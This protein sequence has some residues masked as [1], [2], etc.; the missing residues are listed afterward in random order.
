MAY[1]VTINGVDR[2]TD[3][4]SQSIVIEDVIND[5]TNTCSF[6]LVNNSGNGIPSN[7]TEIVITDD[8]GTKLF[9]GYV[10]KTNTINAGKVGGTMAGVSCVDYV[11]LLDRNLVHKSYENQTDAQIIADIVSTYCPGF[12]ITTTNVLTGVTIEQISFNY[13]QVSQAMRKICE[14]TG[15]NWYID[16][17]KDVHYFPLTTNLAP[18][19]I[20]ST[21]LPSAE[22]FINEDMSVAPSGTLYSDASFQTDHVRLTRAV[23]SINGTLYY[24]NALSANFTAEFD[25]WTGGGNG[26]DAVWFIWGCSSIPTAENQGAGYQGYLVAYDEYADEIQLWYDGTLLDNI[27]QSGM[28]NSTERLAKI[29]VTGTNIKI[30]LDGVLKID[31]DDTTRTLGGTYTGVGARTGGLNNEHSVYRLYVYAEASTSAIDFSKLQINKDASQLKNRVYVRGGTKLSDGVTYIEVGDGQKTT[32]VLPDKPHDVTVYVDTG[33]G[34]VAKTLGIKNIDLTGF[35]WY[36]NFQEKYVEQDSGG[37]VL[38]SAHKLKVTYTYDI[39]IL[40]AVENTASI[41]SNGVK[42]F[43]IFDKSIT[44]TQAARD[45][46]SAELTDYANNIIEGSFTT[47][48]TGFKSGQYININQTAYGINDDYIV[49]KVVS[50]SLGGG[51]YYFEV[52]IASSKT[53]GII[54]FLIELL[55][56]NKNLIE[57]DDNEV[58]DELYNVSDALISDSLTESLTIDSAGPYRTWCTDSLESTATRAVW[59]LFEWGGG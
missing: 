37:S 19:N 3:V 30:Y 20:T 16:Y 26:A 17:D 48:E 12:G 22:E 36:L 50:R 14:L 21:G 25:F 15:R 53:M 40:V 23:N 35:D 59:N 4:L 46:A 56:A 29:V 51:L 2:T 6:K 11:R 32:F 28:D 57:L 38:T 9:G 34:Y 8:N 52:S 49:Q 33:G 18:F 58:V 13:I 31:Y 24:S 54:R 5:K 7:D 45:R 55:E 44:T 47:F 42:E 27:N 43:A 39:P 1:N 10:I 41:N